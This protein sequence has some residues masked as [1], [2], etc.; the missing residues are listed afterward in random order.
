[1]PAK[2][3]AYAS[4][5]ILE[6][7]VDL[8]AECDFNWWFLTIV[9][10]F[11]RQQL[12][13]EKYDVRY[14]FRRI[15]FNTIL[16][17]AKRYYGDNS[18]Q[19]IIHEPETIAERPKTCI[20]VPFDATFFDIWYTMQRDFHSDLVLCTKNRQF[21]GYDKSTDSVHMRVHKERIPYLIRRAKLYFSDVVIDE[22]LDGRPKPLVCFTVNDGMVTAIH[23]PQIGNHFNFNYWVYKLVPNKDLRLFGTVPDGIK[24]QFPV[25]YLEQV[26]AA[27]ERWYGHDQIVVDGHI[28]IAAPPDPSHEMTCRHLSGMLVNSFHCSSRNI[29]DKKRVVYMSN[30]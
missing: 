11:Q 22:D 20:M 29:I 15:Y 8:F 14:V 25:D 12:P 5:V 28:Q 27:A 17:I 13:K 6:Y 10:D 23:N 26:K 30:E 19:V 21:M 4:K 3:I 7:T 18:V 2:F 16:N 9:P 24:Y 1:M